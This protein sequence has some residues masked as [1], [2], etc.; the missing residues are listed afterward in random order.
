[1]KKLILVVILIATTMLNYAQDVT[2]E[3][4]GTALTDRYCDEEDKIYWSSWRANWFVTAGIGYE[5]KILTSSVSDI[6]LESAPVYDLSIGK[7]LTPF[8]GLQLK[9][10]TVAIKGTTTMGD[11]IFADED[12]NLDGR[13][14]TIHLDLMFDMHSII[15]G[16][17]YDRFY[18]I[19]PYLGAG[20]SFAHDG[21]GYYTKD[22]V[23][24]GVI[25]SF[26]ITDSFGAKMTF[27]FSPANVS[28][29][30][31]DGSQR[32]NRIYPV[33][34]SVGVVYKFGSVNRG[35]KKPL[36]DEIHYVDRVVVEKEY[37]VDSVEVEK[38]VYVESGEKEKELYMAGTIVHFELN[39]SK[40]TGS[41]RIRLGY[42]ADAIKMT[43]GDKVFQII[44]YCD[45][46]TGSASWNEKL[47]ARRAQVVYDCLV[48]EFE[49]DPARLTTDHKGGVDIMFYDDNSLSRAVII[50]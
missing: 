14:S 48:N 18:R 50:K 39:S 49:V 29:Y 7:W 4:Y 30:G 12:G 35:Y 13:T 11:N 17:S 23:T 8:V 27:K 3:P 33:S 42:L 24:A 5:A 45:V 31:S 47:S 2:K 41:N 34:L 15:G 9:Y 43:G 28:H 44:G 16:Y 25:N 6:S 1:M 26:R 37:V 36:P 32:R 19:V 10:N 22:Y 21:T 20:M 46:Q 38:V 40:L